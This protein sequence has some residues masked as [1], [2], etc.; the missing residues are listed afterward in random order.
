MNLLE[1][2]FTIYDAWF[3][4]MFLLSIMA[5]LG[6]SS[7][8]VV[9]NE[10]PGKYTSFMVW[11]RVL[12][13][14]N[15]EALYFLFALIAAFGESVCS[16]LQPIYLGKIVDLVSTTVAKGNYDIDEHI[17]KLSASFAFIVLLE[18]LK[19]LSNFVNEKTNENLGDFV[20]QRVQASI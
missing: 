20:R 2:E 11:K 14:A 7:K 16:T 15:P 8:G 5:G 4:T 1:K 12:G 10:V 6:T 17:D 3:F 9:Q 13:F 19:G 18:L